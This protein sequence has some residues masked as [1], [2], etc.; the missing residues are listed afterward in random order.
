MKPRHLLWKLTAGSA[1]A[2]GVTAGGYGVA[3]AATTAA[4]P[5]TA[6]T[7]AV[8]TATTRP[9][10]THRC[11][12]SS[13]SSSVPPLHQPPDPRLGRPCVGGLPCWQAARRH[14]GPSSPQARLVAAGA[15]S[16][17]EVVHSWTS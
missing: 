8:T 9:L 15:P 2:L 10:T 11:P 12:S 1:L 6:V 4:V 7:G 17:W 16:V 3:S 13:S 14:S 5:A